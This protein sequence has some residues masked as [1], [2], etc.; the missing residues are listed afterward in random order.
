M[1]TVNFAKRAALALLLTLPA[2]A[3]AQSPAWPSK[4]IKWIVPYTPGG[5]TDNATRMVVQKVQE[6]TGWT[7]VIENKPG[8]N[9]MLGAD[10]A[11]RSAPDG[12]TFL[13]VIGAHA[14]NATLYAGRMPYDP[15]KSFAPVSLVGIAPLVMTV[16]NNLPVKDVKELIAYSKANPGKVAFGSSGVGAAAHLTQ[17]LFKQASGADMVHVPYKG[18]APA[19]ADLMGGNLQVLTDTASAMM[20]H[21]RSGKIKPLAVFSNKRVP[22]ATE[23]PTI[24]EAGGPAIEGSTWV[25]FLAPSAT[26]KDIVN[27]M[28]AE[29]AKA[30]NSPELRAKFEALGIESV[31]SSPEQAGKFLDEEIVKWA[32]VINAA[33]VK[34]D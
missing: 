9:S 14:A 4:P 8:A 30:I 28:S 7:I 17:E 6:Q 33:G 29:T 23:V 34:A 16:S 12:H 19:L 24:A 32:K 5:I 15:V 20:P 2:W 10:L 1:Q 18:T 11:A 3:Q 26:S 27:R 31:G 25:L 21:V 22:G 13:T